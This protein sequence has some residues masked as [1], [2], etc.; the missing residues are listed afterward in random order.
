MNK[1]IGIM[2]C[3]WLGLPLAK[4]LA[5]RG[6]TVRGTTTSEA[7]LTLLVKSG[8]APF[9]ISISEQGIEGNITS[10]LSGLDV[11]IINIPPALRGGNTS[12]YVLK[13]KRLHEHI[14]SAGVARVIFVSSTSVYGAVSGKVTENTIPEPG[15]ASGRQLLRAEDLFRTDQ[16]LKTAIVRFGGLIGPDRH[17]AR[18]LAGRK[19]LKNGHHP[20]NLIHLDDCIALLTTILERDWWDAIFNGVSPEHPSKQKYYRGQAEKM[21]LEPPEFMQEAGANEGKN[22]DSINLPKRGFTFSKSIWE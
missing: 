20:V 6:Y 14:A 18:S 13:L 15:S 3:G 5:E 16:N 9:M 21:G 4:H 19:D 10:F 11:I 2:G 1:T 12:D 8:V 22:V 7:K 17:P